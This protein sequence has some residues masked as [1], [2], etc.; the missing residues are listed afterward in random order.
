MIFE[1]LELCQHVMLRSRAELCA[2]LRSPGLL[3][4]HLSAAGQ[5]HHDDLHPPEVWSRPRLLDCV[6]RSAHENQPNF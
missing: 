5:A 3:H 1:I 4:Q 2:A 6:R